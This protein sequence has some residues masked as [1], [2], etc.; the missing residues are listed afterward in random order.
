M[1]ATDYDYTED[2]TTGVF[3]IRNCAL[4]K[5]F[6]GHSCRLREIKNVYFSALR[7]GE[8]Q[9]QNLQ[10]D[11]DLY[12]E[13]E[14]EFEVIEYCPREDLKRVK[15]IYSDHYRSMGKLY[16]GEKER[17]EKVGTALTSKKEKQHDKWDRNRNSIIKKKKGLKKL[18]R[19]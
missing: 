7:K 5:V 14:F 8:A 4:G 13:K 11:F 2:R 9:N 12:G 16:D 10:D 18:S 3:M 1:V 17:I 15:S 6:I 19:A